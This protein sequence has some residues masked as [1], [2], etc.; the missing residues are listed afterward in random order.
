MR[1][2]FHI[3]PRYFIAITVV[4]TLVM[5]ISAVV[6]LQQSRREMLHVMEEEALSLSET[7]AH[8]GS[9]NL[10]SMS[11]IETLLNARLL[12]NAHSIARLDSL[13][14]LTSRDLER[15]AA[16]ND[17]FRINIFN[18]RGEKVLSS[19]EP[20]E[21]HAGLTPKHSPVDF[22]RPILRG[23]TPELVIGLK[24]A[25]VEEG[26]RYAVAV[27]RT[28]PGGGA[29]V[30][31]LDA[32]EF[33]EYRKRVGIGKLIQDIGDNSGIVFVALQDSEGIIAASGITD[34][35]GSIGDDSLLVRLLGGGAPLT[36]ES[37]FG[38]VVVFEVARPLLHEGQV[39]GLLRIGL[40]MDE[41]RATETRMERRM[42][43]MSVVL[44]VI[45]VLL[46][47]VV[48]SSQNF[49]LITRK[50]TIARNVTEN[51][52]EHMRDAV[53]TIDGERKISIVNGRA[54]ELLGIVS[55]DVVGMSLDDL[56]GATAD[57]LRKAFVG[58][59][60]PAESNLTDPHG[61]RRIVS[62]SISTTR[63]GEGVAERTT[64]V[65]RD[66]TETRELE[67]EIRRREKL[68]AMG[69]LA[70]GVA[71]E[72]RNPVNAI[73]MIAQRFAREFTPRK[74]VRE[75]RAM[76]EV[77]R[78]EATR[79]NSII[80]QFLRY[81]R[82]PELQRQPVDIEEF[83]DHLALLVREQAN[84]KHIAFR[85]INHAHVILQ[86]DKSQMTQALLNLLQNAFDATPD[87]GII[88]FRV[89]LD[90]ESARISV[91]DSGIGIPDNL[92]PRIFDLYFTTKSGGTGVGLAIAHQIVS[93]HG[94]TINVTS[95]PGKGSEFTISLP[96]RS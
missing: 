4:V 87:G 83:A 77:L 12:D 45:G 69:E 7:I 37:M 51:I 70:A 65:I 1:F 13:G 20:H 80:Q 89:A 73:G 50:Y 29:I 25:R 58:G 54:E 11:Q 36:R 74:G 85:V 34:G 3:Q 14:F 76:T 47:T 52:L 10:L 21:A 18:R 68:S 22:I 48:V 82:P 64:A 40:S 24:P 57:W 78:T 95:A 28:R 67:T 91:R 27:R 53:V 2:P 5:V 88:E 44:A 38:D 8:S 84:A 26:Q 49:A 35:L 90:S 41:I 93:A 6:E 72:I 17:I 94:G 33:L 31:N 86:I 61:M 81:A 96:V 46:L 55:K 60:E 39:V 15:I 32:A 9:N 43:I 62:T 66:L 63:T 19:Y 92:L 79:T 75:F 42:V 30:L 71:H 56:G 59:P 16:E 23:E